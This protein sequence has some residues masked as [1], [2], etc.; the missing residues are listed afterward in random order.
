MLPPFR[1]GGEWT[2]LPH[3]FWVHTYALRSEWRMALR[4]GSRQRARENRSIMPLPL[5]QGKTV[6]KLTV[7]AVKAAAFA[8]AAGRVLQ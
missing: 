1:S 2:W 4:Y 3:S 8:E 5:P 6:V 7:L